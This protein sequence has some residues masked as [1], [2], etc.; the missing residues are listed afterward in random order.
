MKISQRSIAVKDLAAR[1]KDQR[2]TSDIRMLEIEIESPEILGRPICRS[3]AS[4]MAITAPFQWRT[5]QRNTNLRF[6]IKKYPNG[7]F[8]SQLDGKLSVGDA[9][10]AKGP[11]G[12]ASGGREARPMLL[13]GGGSA[14]RRLVDPG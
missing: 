9:L 5:R 6:I 4:W 7:A 1:R 11:D 2:L 8:S 14:C 13:I 10:I 3:D 12:T